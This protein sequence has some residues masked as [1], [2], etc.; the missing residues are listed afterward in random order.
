MRGVFNTL[1]SRH[2][3]LFSKVVLDKCAEVR[4]WR[5]LHEF[6]L[7]LHAMVVLD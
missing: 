7:I 3:K 4:S 1:R 6:G 5:G 2:C